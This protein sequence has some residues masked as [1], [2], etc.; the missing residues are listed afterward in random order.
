MEAAVTC[1]QVKCRLC[2]RECG[3]KG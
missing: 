1:F 3:K 2:Q